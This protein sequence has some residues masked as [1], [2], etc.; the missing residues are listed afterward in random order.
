MNEY[1]DPDSDSDRPE[2]REVETALLDAIHAGYSTDDMDIS[3]RQEPGK[4]RGALEKMHRFACELSIFHLR[5]KV[6]QTVDKLANEEDSTALLQDIGEADGDDTVMR[7]TLPLWERI[8]G[9]L[10]A[11]LIVKSWVTDPFNELRG[12]VH[13]AEVYQKAQEYVV[14]CCRRH[15]LMHLKRKVRRQ[16]LAAQE[17]R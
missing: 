4:M 17:S 12:A 11:R 6:Q 14:T 10:D 1:H 15:Y 7:K 16:K 9:H 8:Q 2:V 13:Q 3:G 5:L